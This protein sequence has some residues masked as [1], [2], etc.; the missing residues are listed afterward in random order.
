MATDNIKLDIE[1]HN[2]IPFGRW[3]I[4]DVKFP[5]SANTDYVIP[6]M[7]EPSDP[8]DIQYV[9]LRQTMA[10]NVYE[11]NRGIV[12]DAKAWTT[13][14]IVLR[15]DV[16]SWTGRLLLVTLKKPITFSPLDL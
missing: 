9:V 8:Y 10:G 3:Q 11:A 4:V 7:L 5:T 1:L 16:A 13:D 2:R 14:F 12:S 15:S 6:H